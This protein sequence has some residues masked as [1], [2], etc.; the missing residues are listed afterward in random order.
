[1]RTRT[2][3]MVFAI[4]SR[5]PYGS[6]VVETYISYHNQRPDAGVVVRQRYTSRGRMID[7]SK[8]FTVY[9]YGSMSK[10]IWHAVRWKNA[11]LGA[12]IRRRKAA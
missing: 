1:M 3:R 7:R 9:R 10:A 11:E 8:Y 12:P 5:R 6:L 2:R 4:K